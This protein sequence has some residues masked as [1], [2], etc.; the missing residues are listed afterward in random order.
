MTASG[1]PQG[2]SFS[3]CPHPAVI[4]SSVALAVV[5]CTCRRQLQLLASADRAATYSATR[6]SGATA[7]P[8]IT[9]PSVA[10]REP[11]HGQSHVFSAE[12]Q[13]TMQ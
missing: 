5:S 3:S 7:G 13:S 2:C 4:L 11:W 12:F 10:N 8:L 9:V 1:N 6:S